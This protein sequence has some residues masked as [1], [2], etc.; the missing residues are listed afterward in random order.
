[1]VTAKWWQGWFSDSSQHT[2]LYAG[3]PVARDDVCACAL[4]AALVSVNLLD[5][6]VK[7]QTGYR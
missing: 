7:E 4:K 6:H 5:L 2:L 1:M 3:C